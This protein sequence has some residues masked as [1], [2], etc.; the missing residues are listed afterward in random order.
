MDLQT[1]TTRTYWPSDLAPQTRL[2]YH[3]HRPHL[4][5]WTRIINA[6]W[7]WADPRERAW[8]ARLANCCSTALIAQEEASGKVW[9]WLARCGSRLCPFCGRGR[10][11][12]VSLQLAA[13]IGQ[14][15][16]PK[17]IILTYRSNDQPLR[18]QLVT[19]RKALCK[20][21]RHPEWKR[22][23]AGGVYTIEITRNPSTGL[24]HPHLHIV[25]DAEYFPQPL[26]A[27]LWADAMPEGGHV[28]IRQVNDTAVACNEIAK[29]VGQAPRLDDWPDV[30]IVHFAQAVHGTRM[31]Q[32][33]GNAIKHAPPE[34]DEPK[35]EPPDT[36]TLS[37][38]QIAYAANAGVLV[39][40]DLVSLVWSR[41]PI[42]RSY[43][44]AAAPEWC[45]GGQLRTNPA[46]YC[47]PPSTLPNGRTAPHA[48]RKTLEAL[49]TA[50]DLTMLLLRGLIKAGEFTPDA[51]SCD[52]SSP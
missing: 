41:W 43:L 29:Y 24:W 48:A 1:E 47:E 38:P 20:L 2:Q 4:Q 49:D 8:A 44:D 3:L 42:L 10:A 15:K 40:Q 33:F 22:R 34:P 50:L 16:Q 12:R 32:C 5:R 45:H 36:F 6:L 17:H 31:L 30:A 9:P 28:W 52:D 25:V 14:F 51:Y 11:R 18:Q 23:V 46:L 19:L 21:R 26:L 7:Q 27:K 37:I 39:C 35:A 13:I